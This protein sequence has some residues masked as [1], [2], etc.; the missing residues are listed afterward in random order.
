LSVRFFSAVKFLVSVVMAL[1][2]ANTGL[3]LYT[4]VTGGDAPIP[5][6]LSVPREKTTGILPGDY[7]V[8]PDGSDTNDGSLE[9]PFATLEGA[10]DKIRQVKA[11]S[12]LPAGGITVCVKAGEY[13][14]AGLVFDSRDSGE[15]G[16]PVTYRAYGDGAVMLNGGTTL[17]SADFEPVSGDAKNRLAPKAQKNVVQVDLTRYGLTAADWGKLYAIGAFNIAYKYDGDVSGPNQCELF[18]NDARMTLARYPNGD[19]YLKTGNIIDMGE[20]GEFPPQNYIEGW[21]EVRNPRG[22]TFK[23]DYATNRKIKQWQTLD[24]VWLY[25]FFF[26][27]WADSSTPLKAVD[28]KKRTLTTLYGS[29]YAFKKDAIYYFYNVF[30]ELDAPGEWYL[31]RVNGM[32]YLY[33]SATM[34]GADINLSIS[35]ANIIKVNNAAH[36]HFKGLHIKGTR[37]DAVSITGNNCVVEDCVVSN[38]AGS[39]II[40]NGYNN[41]AAGNEIKSMGKGGISLSGGDRLTLTPGNNIADNNHIHHYGEIYKTYWAGVILNGVGNICSHN[42]IHDAPHMAITYGGNDHL[43][44]YNR[45]YDV[46]KQSSDAG[47]IYSG[48]D[49]TAYGNVLRYNAIYNI[50]SGE[51]KPDGIYFDDA[52]SGQTAYGNILVNVPKCGFQLGGG[53][54]LNIYNNIIINAGTPIQYDERARDGVI[55]NGWFRGH[56]N[57]LNSGMWKGLF[58]SPYQ[59]DI[60]KARFPKLALVTSD[61]SDYDNPYF[62]VNP[63]FSVVKNNIIVSKKNSVGSIA[64]SVYTFSTVEDNP[65]YLTIQNP[66]FVD[67]RDGN[68]LLRDNAPVLSKLTGF[69]Q[70]PFDKI[71]RY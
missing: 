66:G 37:A 42:E 60:W 35:T 7:Y 64:D 14:V 70:I 54:E 33:P 27:D 16:K 45:I 58:N 31:D 67:F 2:I 21:G 30:E 34:D 4:L 18:F 23:T 56:V 53:R 11:A 39:G 51:F 49:F 10:R 28:T 3:P 26:W 8:A 17:K 46:V 22:G 44:E 65:I 68:Y 38:C 9:N 20:Y 6:N 57:D 29:Q 40:I 1:I 55:N 19:D 71:G 61:F 43:M 48:R 36:L 69:E 41:R 25:G 24:D 15:A 52:Q 50:G 5:S 13:T 62:A 32:L 59:T 12:G 63:A 47:A